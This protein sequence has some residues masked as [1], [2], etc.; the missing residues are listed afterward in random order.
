MVSVLRLHGP[1]MPPARG[2]RA[3]LNLTALAGMVRRAFR[4]PGAAAVALVINCPG[5]SAVQSSLLHDRIRQEAAE[6]GLPVLA[7]CEDVA[8]S[9]GYWLAT[10]ADEIY[11]NSYSLVGSIGVIAAGFGMT[12][13][14]EKLGLERRLYTAGERKSFHDPFRP[15]IPEDVARLKALLATLHAGFV[16]HVKTRRGDRL[17][18][19][20]DELF[21]GAFWTGGEALQLGLID[22]IDDLR[23]VTRRKFGER[24]RLRVIG[25]PRGLVSRFFPGL[26]LA[27]APELVEGL[28]AGLEA[29]ALWARHGL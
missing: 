10:A 1:I 25:Q 2:F 24:V 9:G 18:G 14:A 20:D 13:L 8:A 17:K 4:Q 26:P 16:Q 19:S 11:A 29:R 27:T 15:E 5:G 28:L 6:R 23:S 3:A 21:S 12:G 7:F 22:G